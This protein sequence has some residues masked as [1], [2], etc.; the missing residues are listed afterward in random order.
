MLDLMRKHARSWLIKVL[1]GGIIIVFVFLYSTGPEDQTS[2]YAAEVNGVIISS[3]LLDSMHRAEEENIKMRYRG[4]IPS[5]LIEKMDLKKRVLGKLIDQ[6]LLLQEADRLGFFVTNEDLIY[7]IRNDRRFYRGGVFDK[8]IYMAYTRALKLTS[9]GYEKARLQEL[10]EERVR[11]LLTDGIKFDPREIK[12]FWHFQNDKLVLSMLLLKPDQFEKKVSLDEKS[13]EAYFKKNQKKY[14]IPRAV[15]LEYVTF[16]WRDLEK[17]M[18][19]TPEEARTYF[20]NNPKE[21]IVPE[22]IRARHIFLNKPEDFTREKMEEVR[23]KMEAIQARLKAGEDFAK[24]AKEESQD[25]ATAQKGGDLG[26]IVR[27]TMNSD[28]EKT[29]FDLEEGEISDPV[30]TDRGY[31]LIRVDEKKPEEQI[32]FDSVKDDIIKKINTRLARRKINEDADTFYEQVYREEEI[33]GPAKESGFE[34][35]KAEAVTGSA[36]LPELGGDPKIVDEVFQLETGEISKLMRSGDTFLVIKL[37]KKTKAR[38][39]ELDEV[40]P[41]VK[42]DCVKHQATVKARQK[43][44]EILA[45]LKKDPANYQALV[46]N[47]GLQWDKLDPIPRTAGLVPRL[48]VAPEV[49]EMLATVCEAA[50]L[51]PSPVPVPEGIAIIRLAEMEAAGDEQ[52]AKEANKF[53]T[54]IVNVRTTEYINGWLKLLR[55]RSE[56]KVNENIL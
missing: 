39:P 24:L 3:N 2:D 16:S 25:E 5:G 4:K 52:F 41:T 40:R 35:K 31:H 50:P 49:P 14:E 37:L 30:R 54:W 46:G 42:R 26:F 53:E 27:K 1:V 11:S 9:A 47:F 55:E 7:D 12:E 51:F 48:G 44:E 10:L 23:K 21:F 36:G 13:L 38:L 28:F 19:T 15:D 32:E 18:N 56:I 45:A 33:K 43:A 17:K 34:V 29:A 20:A 22:K 8:N 6:V